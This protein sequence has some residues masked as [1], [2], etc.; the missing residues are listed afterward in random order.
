MRRRDFIAGLGATAARP[1]AVRAKQS[2][3]VYRSAF[4]ELCISR[5]P[6]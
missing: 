6:Q 1:L 4:Q 3:R 5:R 2:D